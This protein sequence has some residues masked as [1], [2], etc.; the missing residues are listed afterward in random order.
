MERT[1]IDDSPMQTPIM[2]EALAC[3]A[4]ERNLDKVRQFLCTGSTEGNEGWEQ[5][6]SSDRPVGLTNIANTCYLNSLLQV[7]GLSRVGLARS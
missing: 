3:F 1:Q 5:V 4:E 7:R 6:S 2:R